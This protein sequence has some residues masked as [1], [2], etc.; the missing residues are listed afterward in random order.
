[1]TPRLAR[2]PPFPLSAVRDATVAIASLESPSVP[3]VVG[4]CEI[5]VAALK[6]VRGEKGRAVRGVHWEGD[7]LWAWSSGGKLG[8]PAPSQ[9]PGWDRADPGTLDD[10]VERLDLED[11][12]DQED[13]GA[14]VRDDQMD[15]TAE[16]ARNGF[17]RGEDAPL[18]EAVPRDET[19]MKV[20]GQVK[21]YIDG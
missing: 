9:I 8:G 4:V 7:E 18:F 15:N 21:R 10:G 19:E 1:M 16:P 11:G 2:G 14:P 3:L 13:G 17:V 6:N 5:D 12:E 20:K